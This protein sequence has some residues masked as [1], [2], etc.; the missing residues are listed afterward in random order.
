ME[1]ALNKIDNLGK[2]MGSYAN[3]LDDCVKAIDRA[4]Q[5][6]FGVGLNIPNHT[7]SINLYDRYTEEQIVKFREQIR[8]NQIAGLTSIESAEKI[9]IPYKDFV[10]LFGSAFCTR[11]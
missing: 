8:E 2:Q 10:S 5:E 4:T 6:K 9:G 7:E 1:N 3:D 11:K